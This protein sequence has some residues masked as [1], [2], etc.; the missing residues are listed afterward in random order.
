MVRPLLANI[1]SNYAKASRK[2]HPLAFGNEFPHSMAHALNSAAMT[3]NLH[4]FSIAN[5]DL[6]AVDFYLYKSNCGLSHRF[7]Y[8]LIWNNLNTPPDFALFFFNLGHFLL[9]PICSLSRPSLSPQNM[10]LKSLLHVIL[11]PTLPA[12]VRPRRNRQTTHPIRTL[13]TSSSLGI[14]FA[15]KMLQIFPLEVTLS[16]SLIYV[17]PSCF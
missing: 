1:M 16:W 10:H 9:S 8:N 4:P 5:I 15:A 13:L 6:Y 3:S 2:Q 12:F 11:F 17:A 7:Q 14:A